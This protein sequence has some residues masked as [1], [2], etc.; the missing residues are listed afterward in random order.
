[1]H[2]TIWD[3]LNKEVLINYLGHVTQDLEP[4]QQR[5]S[6]GTRQGKTMDQEAEKEKLAHLIKHKESPSTRMLARRR[7]EASVR[8]THRTSNSV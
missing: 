7:R 1:M 2:T 5:G 4:L 3:V 6:K 8:P